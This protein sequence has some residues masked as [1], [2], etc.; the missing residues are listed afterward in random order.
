MDTFAAAAK[1]EYA[2]FKK[3]VENVQMGGLES[4]DPDDDEMIDP[5]IQFPGDI[6]MI[7]AYI[8]A[9]ASGETNRNEF[10]VDNFVGSLAR[11]GIE[12]PVP[13]VSHRI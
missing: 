2:D 9:I 11:Y 10:N 8:F 5:L 3:M 6:S 4:E 7:R 13:C 1:V 12:N